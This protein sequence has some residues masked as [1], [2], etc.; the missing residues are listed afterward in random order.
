MPKTDTLSQRVAKALE[1][2]QNG[3]LKRSVVVELLADVQAHLQEPPTT[4]I[5]PAAETKIIDRVGPALKTLSYSEMKAMQCFFQEPELESGEGTLVAS[6]IA[7]RIGITR[8]VIVNAIRKLEAGGVVTSRSLGMKGT[9]LK[10]LAPDLRARL[11]A[12]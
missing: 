3:S 5:Q 11:L 10:I 7:D 12:G 9:R 8:S 4:A 2:A 6:K 1:E